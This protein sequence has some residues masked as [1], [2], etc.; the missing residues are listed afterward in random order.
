MGTE[1][2][3]GGNASYTHISTLLF[4][5][6]TLVHLNILIQKGGGGGGKGYDE[7]VCLQTHDY[8]L[9]PLC[10]FSLGALLAGG[11]AIVAG[12]NNQL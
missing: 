7:M 8:T 10:L 9:T 5:Q 12:I 2:K 11:A 3:R 4:P 1:R 6:I